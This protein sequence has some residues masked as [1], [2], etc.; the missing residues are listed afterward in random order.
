M[1]KRKAEAPNKGGRPPTPNKPEVFAAVCQRIADGELIK[2]AAKAEG[3]DRMTVWRWLKDSVEFRDMYARARDE[4]AD[5]LA[6]EALEVARGSVPERAASDRL[7]VDTLKWTAAKRRP[8]YYSDKMD[9][10][11][12]GEKLS[13]VVILPPTAE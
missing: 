4:A 9:L 6:D 8:R 12:D 13:G 5:A 11:S 10:T 2:D 3:V 1:T 7:L